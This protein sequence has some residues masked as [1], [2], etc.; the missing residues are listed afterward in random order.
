MSYY[1]IELGQLNLE[2]CQRLRADSHDA[3]HVVSRRSDAAD[4]GSGDTRRSRCNL[5]PD[6]NLAAILRPFVEAAVRRRYDPRRLRPPCST[7]CER[8]PGVAVE[9]PVSLERTISKLSQNELR[10]QLGTPPARSV[11]QRAGPF[12]QDR[13]RPDPLGFDRRVRPA[14]PSRQW[15]GMDQHFCVRRVS[16]PRHLADL[17]RLPQRSPVICQ[18]TVVPA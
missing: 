16:I 6:F 17:R 15:P 4:P 18:A 8:W 10:I 9:L 3:R 13:H 12:G 7:N 5:D 11:D 14:L 1:G 2:T